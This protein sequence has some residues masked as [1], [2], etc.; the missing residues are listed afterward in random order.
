MIPDFR[1]PD[2]SGSASR[3]STPGTS[4]SG[5]R[6]SGCA[7]SSRAAS[8]GRSTRRPAAS[9]ASLWPRASAARSPQRLPADQPDAVTA[10][11][12][13]A[14][15]PRRAGAAAPARACLRAGPDRLRG[16]RLLQTTTP[17]LPPLARRADHHFRPAPSADVSR[18]SAATRDRRVYDSD[19]FVAELPANG[20]RCTSASTSSRRGEPILA[21]L[22]ESCANRVPSALRATG[23]RSSCSTTR[24]AASVPH[25]L[26]HLRRSARSSLSNTI[27]RAT[28]SSSSATTLRTALGA[29]PASSSSTPP[30]TP[31]R[32]RVGTLAERD[33]WSPR[34]PDQPAAGM[35]QRARRPAA[36]IPALCAP[37]ARPPVSHASLPTRPLKSSAA[38]ARTSTTRTDAPY[39]DIVNNVCHVGHSHPR[40]VRAAAEQMRAAEHEH[41]LPARERS[42]T[43]RDRLDRH[44]CPSRSA[45]CFLVNS[46]SEANELALRLARAHTGAARRAW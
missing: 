42:S 45:S 22:D 11:L 14:G 32:S 9:L 46:G 19:A 44:A 13:S 31:R 16:A 2:T 39:L 8:T 27:A 33:V 5:T 23:R 38:R 7:T 17:R 41:A 12:G 15:R 10:L 43:T 34:A 21:P 37:P 3:R 24:P 30:R 18:R 4:T 29:A 35:P 26:R 40:V 1:G 36:R 28:S 6:S 20:A 25:S